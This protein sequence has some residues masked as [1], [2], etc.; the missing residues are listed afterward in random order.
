MQHTIRCN[1]SKN[2]QAPRP[3]KYPVTSQTSQ[4]SKWQQG[5]KKPNLSTC[6]FLASYHAASYGSHIST[7]LT[8]NVAVCVWFYVWWVVVIAV[9]H[10]SAP[11]VWS[12]SWQVWKIRENAAASVSRRHFWEEPKQQWTIR[13]NTTPSR[14]VHNTRRLS[15]V[16]SSEFL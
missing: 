4:P 10:L 2:S 6:F 14:F 16:S 12:D 8:T 11:D 15:R 5:K 13:D 9:E 1:T 7:I 3:K